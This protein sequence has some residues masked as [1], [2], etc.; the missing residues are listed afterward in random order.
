MKTGVKALIWG[1]VLTAVI[2]VIGATVIILPAL[3]NMM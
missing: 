3:L 1:L 2:L